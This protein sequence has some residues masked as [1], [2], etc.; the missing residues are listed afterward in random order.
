MVAIDQQTTQVR[1]DEFA[2]IGPGTLAGQ[3]LRSFWQPVSVSA[4]LPPGRAMPLRILGAEYTLYRGETGEPHVVGFRC[5]HRGTQL[6]T[7]WVEGE[8]IRCFYHGW[9]YDADGACVEQPAE[10]SGFAGRVRIPS[11]PTRDYLGLV[12]AYLG[13]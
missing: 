10:D 12:F 5:A 3:Y 1:G 9:K 2:Y 8:C 6:S 4:D 7:G 11:Y 13:E